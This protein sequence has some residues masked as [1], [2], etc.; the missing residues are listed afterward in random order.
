MIPIPLSVR[1]KTSRIDRHITDDLA[2]LSFRTVAPGGFASARFSLHRPLNLESDE[3][4]QFGRVYIYDGSKQVVWEGRLED[5]GPSAGNNGGVFEIS[6]L[7]PSTHTRDRTAPVVYVESRVSE[8]VTADG[9]GSAYQIGTREASNVTEGGLQI[10]ASQGSVASTTSLGAAVYNGIYAAGQDLH[11][12]YLNWDG[13]FTSANTSVELRTAEDFGSTTTVTTTTI[14][15]AGGTFDAQLGSGTAITANHN[16]VFLVLRRNGATVTVADDLYWAQFYDLRLFGT[17]YNADGTAITTATSSIWILGHEV[18]QDVLGRLL[19]EY[20][21]ANAAITSTTHAFEQLAYTEGATP[22][23]ILADVLAVE[24]D[25]LWEALES[26]SAGKYRFSFRQWP[27]DV[28]YEADVVDGYSSTGSGGDLYN[29]V[30][31]AYVDSQGQTRTYRGTSTVAILD[32]AGKTR[33]GYIHLGDQASNLAN[34]T[35]A[36]TAF[37]DEHAYAPASGRLTIAR[38]IMDHDLSRMVQPWEIRPGYLIRIR[39][40]NSQVGAL[41][42]TARDGAT[43]FRI[44]SVDYNTSDGSAQLELD[45]PA[46]S[47]ARLLANAVVTLPRPSPIRRR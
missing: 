26:N 45:S 8:F 2:D 11:R 6:A 28:R 34:A 24:P 19:P 3:L 31:V 39:D 46:P 1:L 17:R 7:G 30:L 41:T 12:I 42:A 38:P 4:R 40:L 25:F 47:T 32:E 35:A 37:L 43:T 15:T 20:D 36:A 33:E 21:G 44:I 22:E 13:G 18:V 27:S 10:S 14:T 23:K 29:S 9:S 16:R 5:P